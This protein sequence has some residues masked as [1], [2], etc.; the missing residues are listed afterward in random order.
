MKAAKFEPGQTWEVAGYH[1]PYQ[2]TVVGFAPQ[3]QF[4]IRY[5]DGAEK[6]VEVI[7]CEPPPGL[8]I[9]L[10]GAIDGN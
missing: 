7:V 10:V 4:R 1:G 2:F 5:L 3:G 9:H 6:G 8:D